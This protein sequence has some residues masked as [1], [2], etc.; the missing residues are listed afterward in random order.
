[1]DVEKAAASSKRPNI[2][3][4]KTKLKNLDK[5][6]DKDRLIEIAVDSTQHAKMTYSGKDAPRE[7]GKDLFNGN[8]KN[9]KLFHGKEISV[10]NC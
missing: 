1:L 2:R 8:Y 6:T 5:I 7:I 3:M 4:H 10:C 9:Y